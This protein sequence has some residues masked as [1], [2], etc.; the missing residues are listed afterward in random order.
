MS[1]LRSPKGGCCSTSDDLSCSFKFRVIDG[2]YTV[3]I[4]RGIIKH[5]YGVLRFENVRHKIPLI[6]PSKEVRYVLII[7][8]CPP[9]GILLL[10]CH[11]FKLH[12][13]VFHIKV[14]NSVHIKYLYESY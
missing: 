5:V 12:L 11:V 7:H 4:A 9:I 1:Y 13:Y 2:E 3:K 10:I 14:N 8:L 6:T